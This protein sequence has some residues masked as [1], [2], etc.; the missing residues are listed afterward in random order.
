LQQE[1]IQK[2]RMDLQTANCSKSEKNA[3]LNSLRRN[4]Q[5]DSLK[6]NGEF[7][8]NPTYQYSKI[9]LIMKLMF[10][11]CYWSLFYFVGLQDEISKQCSGK[12]YEEALATK[13]KQLDNAQVE[14]SELEST[15]AVMNRW[16]DQII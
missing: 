14:A 13:K 5:D 7:L 16:I 4:E 12:P 2:L 1:N 10:Q 11:G 8:F 3:N 9:I 15:K 6:F